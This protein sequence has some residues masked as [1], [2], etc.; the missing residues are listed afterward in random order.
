MRIRLIGKKNFRVNAKDG[1]EDKTKSTSTA[2]NREDEL[3][4]S[5]LWSGKGNTEPVSIELERGARFAAE[6]EATR[7][8][9]SCW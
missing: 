7:V 5:T 6:F 9:P 2:L 1:G 4:D 8:K 3:R